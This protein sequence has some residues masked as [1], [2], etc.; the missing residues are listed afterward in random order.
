MS[1]EEKESVE[2]VTQ[3]STKEKRRVTGSN[4][5][6]GGRSKKK[7]S[8]NVSLSDTRRKGG[9][10]KEETRAPDCSNF[11][12]K[13]RGKPLMKLPWI[14]KGKEKVHGEKRRGKKKGSF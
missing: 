7:R 1:R 2:V 12:K 10:K 11:E 4:P 6:R 13:K 8:R 9:K 5:P 14:E 3:T